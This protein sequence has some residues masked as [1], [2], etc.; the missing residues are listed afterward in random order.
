MRFI[1]IVCCLSLALVF[2]AC[3]AN[4]SESEVL[5]GVDAI[6]FAKRA[7]I[8]ASGAHDVS[9]GAG[10]VI[11][12][13]R[14]NPGG[15][16]FVLS[17]PKPGGELRE[18]THDFEGV[19]IA[20]LDLSFDAKEVVFSMRHDGDDNFHIYKAL[21]GGQTRVKQ[22]TFGP[23]DDV[24]PIYV[25][26]KR[27]AFVT[28][29][30]YTDLGRRADEY[31]HSR[32]VTQ[33]ATISSESGDAERTLCSHNLSH[34]ADPFLMSDG[35]VGFSRWEHLGPT[36]DVKL[37]K[38]NPDCSSMLAVAGQHNKGFNSIVQ[39]REI[40]PGIMVGIATDRE[41]TIQAGAIMEVDV[42]AES[43]TAGFDGLWRIPI[44]VYR[45]VRRPD[46]QLS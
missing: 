45:R 11:D 32:Q 19:D 40:E 35:S 16:V 9:G 2:G 38:M 10:Q 21:V 39:A 25:P 43:S 1:H 17:P 6:V 31:N 13:L 18:L 46:T 5:P 24:R 37:F 29:E 4:D 28:N 36:N 8:T 44:V 12:Y 33:M 15:G 26:G 7:Y 14:Y 20:G 27:I 30:G 3:K 34:S 23:Y 42:R 41:G 22:L